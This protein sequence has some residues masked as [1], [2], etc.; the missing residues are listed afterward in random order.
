MGRAGQCSLPILGKRHRVYRDTPEPLRL[1]A[2]YLRLAK[3]WVQDN[4]GPRDFTHSVSQRLDVLK[5]VDTSKSEEGED[6]RMSLHVARG[7]P[8]LGLV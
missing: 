1:F 7:S 4:F 8:E 5:D 2:D 6:Y 3:K